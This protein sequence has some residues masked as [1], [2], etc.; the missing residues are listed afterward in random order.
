MWN[1][2]H[3]TFVVVPELRN[4]PEAN[5]HYLLRHLPIWIARGRGTLTFLDVESC[6]YIWIDCAFDSVKDNCGP[7]LDLLDRCMDMQPSRRPL[8]ADIGSELKK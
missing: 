2:D 7:T 5:Y 1:Y 3:I 4:D 6:P 8:A